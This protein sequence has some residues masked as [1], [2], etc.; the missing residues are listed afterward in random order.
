MGKGK[1]HNKSNKHGSTV[2]GV[3]APKKRGK[4]YDHLNNF[5]GNSK[6]DTHQAHTGAVRTFVIDGRHVYG[7]G[8][9]IRF[10]PSTKLVI[11]LAS[12]YSNGAKS[13][14]SALSFIGFNTDDDLKAL[15]P[16]PP[17]PLKPKR[18]ALDWPDMQA[19]DIDIIG[20]DFWRLIWSIMPIAPEG[21][22][23]SEAPH[24]I[25]CCMG[26]HGRTGTC[27]A[28]LLISNAGY[29]MANAINFVRYNHCLR[30]V[31]TTSQ[32]DY[33]RSLAKLAGTNTQP[34]DT[35]LVEKVEALGEKDAGVPSGS[36][37][38]TPG[39]YTPGSNTPSSTLYTP[40][41]YQQPVVHVNPGF[42]PS[43]AQAQASPELSAPQ[44]TVNQPMSADEIAA[45][46]EAFANSPAP[47]L[48]P[49]LLNTAKYFCI[50]G[51]FGLMWV[52][53]QAYAAGTYGDKPDVL[54]VRLV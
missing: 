15:F 20:V 40:G 10:A 13:P 23:A 5:G 18:L 50:Q 47:T 16:P 9:S 44:A 25:I 11:D 7:A 27:M 53:R 8:S 52:S 22:P 26:G 19:P 41:N 49:V 36:K 37:V 43:A 46:K 54:G 28:A 35:S 1:Q 12:S 29:S 39:N 34:L 6:S 32:I 3:K 51:A 14:K 33:L 38:Y 24:T 30:A 21:V 2:W 42:K 48:D 45:Q 31:E 4:M 17:P